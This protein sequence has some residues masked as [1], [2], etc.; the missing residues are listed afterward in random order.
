M[1]KA[2]HARR[3]S[4]SALVFALLMTGFLSVCAAAVLTLAIQ[5]HKLTLR[6]S[7]SCEAR[8]A[9]ES[10]INYGVSQIV[11]MTASGL[12][13]NENLLATQPLK[14]PSVAELGPDGLANIA[15]ADIT[16]QGG[17][18]LI[19]NKA[20]IIPTGNP[21]SITDDAKGHLVFTKT[22]PLL[23][24]IKATVAGGDPVTVFAK[25]H[26]VVRDDP[27]FNYAIFYNNIPLEIAPGGS[28]TIGG[29]VRSNSNIYLGGGG[30]A[31]TL[32]GTI[33][34]AGSIFG[35]RNPNS[36]MSTASLAA[37]NVPY[38]DINNNGTFDPT[39]GWTYN[40]SKSDPFFTANP[41]AELI[42][43]MITDAT[44]SQV[45]LDST[46]KSWTTLATTVTNG[47]VQDSAH[48]VAQIMPPGITSE[49]GIK[50][51]EPPVIDKTSTAYDATVESAKY[52]N[53]A[54]LYL[55]VETD[56]TVTAF[57]NSADAG[58]YKK[59]SDKIK[60]KTDN[61]AKVIDL[62]GKNVVSVGS[63]NDRRENKVVTSVDLN[64]GNLRQS[65]AGT[66]ASSA[67]K[68]A[69][70]T[71]YA[72]DTP[73]TSGWNGIVYVDV[74]NP[75]SGW[76]PF[77]SGTKTTAS[78]RTAVRLV[79][80]GQVP[81]R[82]ATNAAGS[83]GF[84][85]ATNAPL[86]S[87]GNV[88]ADGNSSTGSNSQPDSGKVTALGTECPVSLVADAYTPLSANWKDANSAAND[89]ANPPA[90]TEISAALT[91][92]VVKSAGNKYSG[93]LENYP[94]LLEQWNG[95]TLRIRGSLTALYESRYATGSWSGSYYSVPTRDWGFSAIFSGGVY[96]PGTPVLR[97]YRRINFRVI[98]ESEYK[99]EKGSVWTKA[100]GTTTPKFPW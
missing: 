54:G 15:A 37:V 97:S 35:G 33:S 41:K 17:R 52:A 63:F 91:V 4:A 29:A 3:R 76:K 77:V 59:E 82:A 47:N 13:V 5:E 100:D 61:S 80:A 78:T 43:L 68:F 46:N 60:W 9:L 74:Q 25:A 93:G 86:Y 40:A 70:N 48:G 2:P 31:L 73:D 85:L 99:A 10:T 1:K 6:R 20:V 58:S 30:G 38:R 57:Q 67:L 96:P 16:I 27:L 75:D 94:R 7:V 65:V 24:S 69:N 64:L 50:L 12:F 98:S 84:T 55:Y 21:T 8:N 32:A 18:A 34:S 79:N 11:R 88:N 56:G 72:L 23:A 28:M 44:G 42:N 83:L 45:F 49:Q 51:I 92:G 26:L 62:S 66:A 90:F 22:I 14:A 19:S 39:S 71:A 36:G 95:T 53:K 87:V 81:N 89:T